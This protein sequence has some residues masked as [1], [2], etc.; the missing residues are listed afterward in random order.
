MI[1]LIFTDSEGNRKAQHNVFTM[2]IYR[3][4][5]YASTLEICVEEDGKVVKS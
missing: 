1:T 4:S 2:Q 3:W 5:T